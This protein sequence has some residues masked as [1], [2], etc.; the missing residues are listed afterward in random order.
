MKRKVSL[1]IE[2]GDKDSLLWKREERTDEL[3]PL[4]SEPLLERLESKKTKKKKESFVAKSLLRKWAYDTTQLNLMGLRHNTVK[5]NG[6]SRFQVV[7]RFFYIFQ[8]KNW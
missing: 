7:L 8:K 4:R 5:I 3:S 2:K 1:K 6:L